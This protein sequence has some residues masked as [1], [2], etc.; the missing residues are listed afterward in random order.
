MK[1]TRL[2][3]LYWFKG[4]LSLASKEYH[5]IKKNRVRIQIKSQRQASLKGM[6]KNLSWEDHLLYLFNPGSQESRK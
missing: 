3:I 4:I 6:F 1:Y 5:I 2:I